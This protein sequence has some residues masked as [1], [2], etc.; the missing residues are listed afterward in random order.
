MFG[1]LQ[2]NGMNEAPKIWLQH[3]FDSFDQDGL[4]LNVGILFVFLDLLSL[5]QLYK[6]TKFW[7]E[8]SRW[9]SKCSEVETTQLTLVILSPT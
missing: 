7:R 3:L 1:F 6:W 8:R 4:H 2:L 5:N 9:V